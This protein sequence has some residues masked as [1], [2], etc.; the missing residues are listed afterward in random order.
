MIEVNQIPVSNVKAMEFLDKA[1]ILKKDILSGAGASFNVSKD[2]MDFLPEIEMTS[3]KAKS[4]DKSDIIFN[5]HDPRSGIDR[6]NIGFSIKSEMGKDPTLFNTSK[7]SGIIYKVVGMSEELMH[8]VNSL[9]DDK[10][11]AVI[12]DRCRLMIQRGCTLEYQGY[13]FAKRA[14]C[15]AFEEN[16][17]LIN[18]RLPEVIEWI[19]WNHFVEKNND[20]NIIDII[21]LLI[22]FKKFLCS[23]A[24][25]LKPAKPWDGLDEANGG[26]IIVKDDG[27]VLAYHI[28]NR[29]FFEQ[30]LLENTVFERASTRRHEYMNLYV[31][32]GQIY[33]KLNLQIRFK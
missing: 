26:Y 5:T 29:N 10:G 24:L 22:K 16:L 9:T 32:D 3:L 19:L 28:Y 21:K 12:S 13:E 25:G 8:E 33:I 17:D 20:R 11:H 31:E 1:E 4:V 14:K 18:P 27:E 15:Q 30:Y 2:V 23:C 7:A 6:E